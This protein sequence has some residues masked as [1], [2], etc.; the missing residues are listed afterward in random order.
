MLAPWGGGCAPHSAA[1]SPWCVLGRASPCAP[2]VPVYA[3]DSCHTPGVLIYWAFLLC[4]A[5]P[6]CVLGVPAYTAYS[7]CI[8]DILP[9]PWALPLH[10]VLLS[11]AGSGAAAPDGSQGKAASLFSDFFTFAFLGVKQFMASAALPHRLSV[12]LFN[13]FTLLA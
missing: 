11:T 3:G 13:F 4:A 2:G 12:M 10:P 6:S 1:A 8:W 5:F 7:C 9:V